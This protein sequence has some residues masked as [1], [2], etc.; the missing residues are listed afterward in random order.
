MRNAKGQFIQGNKGYWL[1]KKR[2][3]LKTSTSFVKGTPSWNKG[4]SMSAEARAKMSVAAKGRP[5]PMKGRKHS[6]QSRR[7]MSRAAFGKPK[8]A[9]PKLSFK[10]RLRRTTVYKSW[11]KVI[12]QRDDYTCQFCFKRGV[13]LQVDHIIPF[14]VLVRRLNITSYFQA[15]SSTVL[16]SQANAR[17]LCIDCHKTTDSYLNNFIKNNI[18]EV[19]RGVPL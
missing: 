17:T 10:E 5:S 16:W 6:L 2:P 18:Y 1:G 3:G 7:K 4:K 19:M 13:P 15:Y 8:S 14:A 9:L 12:L 11:V